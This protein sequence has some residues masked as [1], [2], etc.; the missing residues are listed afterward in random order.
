MAQPLDRRLITEE[1]ANATFIKT[2]HSPIPPKWL[3]ALSETDTRPLTGVLVGSS[4]AAGSVANPITRRFST[5]LGQMFQSSYNPKGIRGGEAFFARDPGAVGIVYTGTT[6]SHQFGL[7][8]E[9]R[10]MVDTEMW[11]IT[12]PKTTGF[13]IFFTEG[14][15]HGDLSI[16]IDS[17]TPYTVSVGKTGATRYTRSHRT[18]VLT[19]GSHVIKV[20]AVGGIA[21]IDQVYSFLDDQNVGV[22]LLQAGKGGATISTFT[23]EATGPSFRDRITQI[24]PDFI[25]VYL[26]SNEFSGAYTEAQAVERF[27]LFV[28]DI[29]N[30]YGSAKAAPWIPLMIMPKR[31]DRHESYA[32]VVNGMKRV[33]E[34][35]PEFMSW[36]DLS[37]IYPDTQVEDNAWYDFISSDSVHP[38][39]AGHAKAAREAALSLGLPSQTIGLATP[40]VAEAEGTVP[41]QIVATMYTSDGFS[42]AATNTILARNTDVSAGGTVKAWQGAGIVFGLDGAGNLVKGSLPMTDSGSNYIDV[43][44]TTDVQASVTFSE[45]PTDPVANPGITNLYLD[46]RRGS[47]TG[48]S[49]CYRLH[50]LPT[51]V[52]LSK[53]VESITTT[54]VTG[55]TWNPG[56]KLTLRALGSKISLLINGVDMGTVT[57]TDLTTG[58][59]N[60]L[61]VSTVES[62]GK[63]D[64]FTLETVVEV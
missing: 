56:D 53:R 29:V 43:T 5:L 55:K 51:V 3:A 44:E 13:E 47:G 41:K 52:T 54:L 4:T 23:T 45:R 21:I 38:T 49:N 62:V 39:N 64:L 32:P 61:S 19:E 60:G 35:H 1:K 59:R 48:G 20:T 10:R 31:P 11:R 24:K 22:R 58:S 28:T 8:F 40:P 9:A 25:P 17:E 15:G 57:D 16:Q 42:G 36:H 27:E 7:G 12:R 37:T 34:A 50:I 18:R 2:N 33:A 14:A 63:V 26:G 6:V 30:I 46:V